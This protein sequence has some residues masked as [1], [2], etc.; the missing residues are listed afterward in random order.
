MQTIIFAQLK[1]LAMQWASEASQ[2]RRRGAEPQ[3]KAVESCA[4][5]LGQALEALESDTQPM[6]VAQYARANGVET[7]T[8]RKWIRN[9]QLPAEKGAAGEWRIPRAAVRTRTPRRTRTRAH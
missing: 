5:E 1:G 8:V 2:L 3:A 9:G 7:A 6:T 4:D